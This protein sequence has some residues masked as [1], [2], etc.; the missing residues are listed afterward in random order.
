[1]V[2]AAFVCPGGE[3]RDRR[4]G[5]DVERGAFAHMPRGAVEPIKQVRAAW[6]RQ[7]ALGPVHEAVQDERVVR[8]EQLGHFYGLRHAR[9]ADPL[10]DV[11]LRYLA[12]AEESHFDV[13]RE[14][15]DAEEPAVF[16]SWAIDSVKRRVP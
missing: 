15:M 9:L 8:T 14:A 2:P 1:M 6:T 7:L 16:L 13:V 12:A 5:D 4:F 11:V 10:E 3:T